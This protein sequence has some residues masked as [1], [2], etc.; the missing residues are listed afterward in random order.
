MLKHVAFENVK[1][2]VF[3]HFFDDCVTKDNIKSLKLI[4]FHIE[5]PN[6][7]LKLEELIM[8]QVSVDLVGN[9]AFHINNTGAIRI[10]DSNFSKINNNLIFGIANEVSKSY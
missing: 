6:L 7:K 3:H 10:T 5:K 9:D 2:A 4:N 8:N 1:N